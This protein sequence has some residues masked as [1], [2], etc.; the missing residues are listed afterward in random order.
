MLQAEFTLPLQAEI[1]RPTFWKIGHVG[2]AVFYF[3]A[4][5]TIVVAVYGIYDR[6]RTYIRGSEDPFERLD[7]LVGRT[8][9]GARIVFSNQKQFERD[10]VG[11]LMHAAI[12][13]GFLV[14][15]IGTAILTVDMDFYRILFNDSF[16]V[17]DFYQSYSLVLDAFGLLFVAGLAV[18]IY[19]RYVVR[20]ERLWGKHTSLE[21]D[22]FVWGLFLIGLSGFFEEGVRILGEG[23]PQYETVS[24][25][26]YFV[27]MVL[28][29]AGMSQEMAASIFAGTWW[30]HGLVALAFIAWIP[31]A[32][33]FHMLSSFANVIA[34]DADAGSRLPGMPVDPEADTDIDEIE[35]FTWKQI[36]DQDACTKCG[37][38]SSVC[39]ADEAGRP[40][41]P[42][43]VILDLKAHRQD[44]DERGAVPIVADGGTSVIDAETMESCMSCM[45][46]MDACPV[47]IEH[48]THFTDM[49][50]QLTEQ[51]DI[52]SN[53]QDVFGNLM[54]QGN[55]FGESARKRG[56]WTEELDFEVPDAR[57]EDVD[58]LWYVGDYPS[59][60]ERN[61]QV[62]EAM[63]KLFDHADVDYG[64]LYEDE[65]YDG[66]DIRRMG[67]ELLFIE[68]AATMVGAIEDADPETVVCTDPHSY[69]T[70]RNEY[71]D[72]DFA[73]FADDPM[74]ESPVDGYWNE[75]GD[76]AV[77]H[78]TQLIEEFVE[79]GLLDLG[80]LDRTVTYHDPC[81]LGRYNDEYEAPRE[82]VRA[83]GADLVEMPRNRE[84]AFCCGGGGGGLWL[85]YDEEVKPS[86]E[87]LREAVVDT[88][89]EPEEFVV[90]CPMCM[91]MF[92]DGRKT[93]GYEDDIDVVDLLELLLESI[94]GEPAAE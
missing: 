15:A 27:A 4:A 31:Y 52:D 28:D 75:D 22:L 77:Q 72:I 61:Q 83:T 93:G 8:A 55:T 79:D 18:A 56:E 2:K 81:H 63:A 84:D 7:G 58:I 45:A 16:F 57:D 29:A 89:D 17:G 71:T 37:R 78:Y 46:C 32:K 42:R 92:E 90:A 68:Q 33:P 35:D 48:L 40:L 30:I 43:D 49:N 74:L 76:I 87:R 86:E 67:E 6:V 60:D 23:M 10:W 44:R 94:E 53:V 1:T 19:R 50:R 36:L 39:P 66:N 21:D 51:G 54:Q 91:T 25:V 38:C 26:G 3:L 70:M 69:N 41:N 80:S 20:N 14:L 62:A 59:F 5:V 65:V 88:E 47:E 64:I 11:G 85:D 12:F 9:E 24:F 73:E 82:L 34:R 13:W